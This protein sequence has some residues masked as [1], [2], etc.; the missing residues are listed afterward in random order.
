VYRGTRMGLRNLFW[1][2]ADASA[3]EERFTTKENA[4]Q[5]PSAISPDGRWLAFTKASVTA[6]NDI[7]LLGLGSDRTLQP[8]LANASFSEEGARFSP[9]GRWL[10]YVSDESGR[11]EVYVQAF[12]GPGGRRLISPEGGD[13]PTW[14]RTGRELFYTNEN[15][16]IIVDLT[17]EPA[18]S[19]GL[20]R[21]R[22]EGRFFAGVGPSTE[23]RPTA[24]GSS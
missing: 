12:P 17:T 9:D 15:G 14:S 5:V 1:R 23:F 11:D 3:P 22:F 10:A 19:A 16:M 6:G 2:A 8:L 24:S 4:L 20:P 7:W 21:L 18:L 13:R